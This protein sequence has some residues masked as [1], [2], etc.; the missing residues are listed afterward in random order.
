MYCKM[1]GESGHACH[2][3][4]FVRQTWYLRADE[5]KFVDVGIRTCGVTLYS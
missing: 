3:G 1:S 4:C 2:G 5:V